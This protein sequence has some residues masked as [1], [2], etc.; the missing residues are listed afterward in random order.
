MVNVLNATFIYN[1]VKMQITGKDLQTMVT[2]TGNNPIPLQTTVDGLGWVKQVNEVVTNIRALMND[3]KPFVG[4]K[5]EAAMNDDKIPYRPLD[6]PLHSP[7]DTS[8]FITIPQ[9]LLFVDKFFTGLESQG[10]GD[11]TTVEAL[12]TLNFKIKDLHILYQ[13]WLEKQK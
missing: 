2:Q 10:L 7:V 12:G 8:K 13:L 4:G 5:K 3:I 1:G 6:M 9:V 11:K